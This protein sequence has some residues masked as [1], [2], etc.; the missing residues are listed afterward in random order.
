MH[1]PGATPSPVFSPAPL[2]P[3]VLR[4]RL[5][6]SAAFEGMCPD[7]L[8]SE[9]LV[10]HH[11]QMAEGGV[12]LTT[13]AYA[14]VSPDGRTYAHQ[15]L[16]QPTAVGP[17][18]RLTEAVHLAGALASVQLGH[19]GD[20]AASKVIGR[21]PLGPSTR[22]N[23]YAL[24]LARAMNDAD[25]DR[26]ASDFVRAARLAVEA[27]FDAVELQLCHGY[28]LSQFLSPYANHRRDRY[29]GSLEGRL[30]YPLEVVRRVREA[31]PADKALVAKVNLRDGFAGG[32]ELDEAVEVGRALEG[33]GVDALFLSGG[34]VSK[35]PMYI[36]R[37]DVPFKDMYANQT[38]LTKKVGLL[39]VGR[40]MVK[41]FPFTEAYFLDEARAM[42]AAV[43][44]PLILVGGIRTL[45]RMEAI[46]AEGIEFLGL[47]RPLIMEPDLPRLLERGE[48]RASRC[49]PC[50][51]CIAV[52][53]RG[54]VRC[55]LVSDPH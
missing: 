49:V 21:R 19:S 46:V 36:M 12:A 55:P 53:D 13:V 51:R 44:L 26:V 29:G 17:L 47:A 2:G 3:L 1:G 25:L 33:A 24:T 7:G 39:L 45:A 48:A 42:R 41:A 43:R 23:T 54:A 22:Y 30:R 37:G 40:L 9:A 38:D 32:L 20:F 8:P 34:F 4:N 18:R 50:N 16:M 5:V 15:L 6:R 10:A 35:V 52:M 14:S 28:L 31:L 11:R 27:G